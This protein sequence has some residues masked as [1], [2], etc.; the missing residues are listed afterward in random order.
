VTYHKS[1]TE[2]QKFR[3]MDNS[4]LLEAYVQARTKMGKEPTK[5][6][7]L[8]A[9]VLHRMSHFQLSEMLSIAISGIKTVVDGRG[10]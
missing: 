2:E 10:E 3:D 8:Q 4:D 5:A 9:L 1:P 7:H 6:I